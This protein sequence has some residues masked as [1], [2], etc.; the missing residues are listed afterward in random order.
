MNSLGNSRRAAFTLIELLVVI[1]IIAILI[2]C[3][4]PPSWTCRRLAMRRGG[5]RCRRNKKTIH[6]GHEGHEE[7]RE[8]GYYGCP[9][10]IHILFCFLRVL[11]VLRG[12]FSSRPDGLAAA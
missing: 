2:A 10:P 5:W 4:C 9:P 7:D 1:A 11:R 6:E 3:S 12:S 8:K